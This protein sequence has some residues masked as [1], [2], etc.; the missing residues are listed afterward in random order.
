M[1]RWAITRNAVKKRAR[2]LGVELLRP[3]HFTCLWPGDAL[4]LGEQ[5]HEHLQVG[6]PIRTFPGLPT[7]SEAKPVT[8]TGT[9]PVTRPGALLAHRL[10]PGAPLVS[11]PEQLA[12]LVAALRP[13]DPLAHAEAL[14]R[15]AELGVPLS[16]GELAEVIGFAAST[17]EGWKDGRIPRPGFILRRQ[18]ERKGAPVWWLVERIGSG[19]GR[20]TG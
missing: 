3:D 15:A 19:K 8:A 1:Q 5:L 6:R 2:E 9:T 10:A 7:D 17:V 14:A 18:Q 13:P 11:A 4:D 12:A 20:K 16:S